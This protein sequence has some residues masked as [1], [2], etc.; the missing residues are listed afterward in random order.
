MTEPPAQERVR[1]ALLRDGGRW[2]DVRLAGLELMPDGTVELLRVPAVTPPHIVSPGS[3]EP[4]GLALDDRCGLYIADA[5]GRRLMRDALD[6]P[7]RLLVP[8]TPAS[9]GPF[10]GPRGICIGPF[11][12]LFVA[13]A[14]AGKVL[15]LSTPDLSVRDAWS[16]GL[17]RPIAVAPAG[18]KG[19]YVLDVGLDRIL[20]FDPFGVPDVAFDAGFGPPA[21]PVHPRAIAAAP[22]G[23]LYVAVSR[24]VERFTPTGS[25]A[26][27]RLALGTRTQA[28]AVSG[29]VLYVADEPS[30]EIVLFSVLDGHELG[31][32]GGFRGPVS[33]LATSPGGRVYI[34][35]DAEHLYLVAEPGAGRAAQGT[36]T[37]SVPLRAGEDAYWWRATVD[38]D[39][40]DGAA[41]VLDLAA[42]PDQRAPR[43]R[44]AAAPDTLVEPLLGQ[45]EWLW[46]R[47]TLVANDAGGS[48]TLHQVRAETAGDEY[49]RYLPAVYS[50]EP[51]AAESLERLLALAKAQLG[52]LE[53]EIELL[54]RRFRAA[55]A[56]GADLERLAQWMAFPLPELVSAA[57][58]PGKLRRLLD[59]VRELDESRGTPR[60]LQRA[61][62]IYAGTSAEVLEEFRT[63][64][65]WQLGDAALGFDSQLSPT[66][67]DGAVVG[68]T[69][70]G[71]SGPESAEHWGSAL[72]TATAHRFSV[73]VPA[74]QAPTV[75]D[76]RRVRDTIE[77]EKPAHAAYH[78]CFT[79]PKL[80]VGFQ[81][82]V[83]L[84]A[85][86]GV[87]SD[88]FEL[89]GPTRLGIETRTADEEEPPAAVAGGRRRIGIDALVG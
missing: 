34:K 87:P 19:V 72:F 62:E 30:G 28:L 46:L 83:G 5:H 81:A 67:V 38:A 84:D 64:G 52:D 18:V 49:S 1:H 61:L 41:V 50:R 58:D 59:E 51:Q 56:S 17:S 8:G 13:D 54:A 78:L 42:E 40:P 20:R 76:Q 10:D 80:R 65:V 23:T 12:W 85:I 26:G 71:S 27:P 3:A 2:P 33:A 9:G 24:G 32:V 43:W 57:R 73:L 70:V 48:P 60:G 14:A 82:R 4:S 86:V 74:A 66:A 77:R 44:R 53:G 36:L 69:A 47:V 79:G 11:G 21:G 68:S 22:D 89:D 35:N 37:T 45:A 39:I 15:V 55:T 6:C 75:D 88:S 29:D 25:S 16:A 7:A 63:R 31:R